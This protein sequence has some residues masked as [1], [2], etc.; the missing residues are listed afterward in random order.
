[1][2]IGAAIM[3]YFVS[4]PVGG[5]KVVVDIWVLRWEGTGAA[6]GCPEPHL[7]PLSG[8]ASFGGE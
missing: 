8:G 4:F 7:L 6:A 5:P 3:T 1:M 2:E